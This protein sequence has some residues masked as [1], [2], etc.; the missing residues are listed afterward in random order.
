MV[1]SR[2]ARRR[3][4]MRRDGEPDRALSH[5]GDRVFNPA[6]AEAVRIRFEPASGPST[7]LT[8]VDGPV[9]IRATR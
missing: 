8:I 4:M 2:D 1:V 9:V 6:G 3:L 5:H 7:T